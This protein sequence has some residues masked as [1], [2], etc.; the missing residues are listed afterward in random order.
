MKGKKER[1]LLLS[2]GLSLKEVVGVRAK[3]VLPYPPTV[4]NYWIHVRNKK[5]LS[6]RARDFQDEVLVC[7]RKQYSEIDEPLE[8]K[9]A[10]AIG[11][12]VPDKRKRDIDNVIKPLFDALERARL[13]VNDFQIDYFCVNRLGLK[14]GGQTLL[15]VVEIEDE[16]DKI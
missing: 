7:V 4:N 13:F 16:D 9:L 1:K 6:K 11:L 15:K 12:Y 5:I 10:M 3:L 14:K 8:C 2:T